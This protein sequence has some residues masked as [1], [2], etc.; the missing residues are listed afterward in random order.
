[1]WRRAVMVFQDSAR[2]GPDA[3]YNVIA[4]RNIEMLE[5]LVLGSSKRQRG[6]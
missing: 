5:Q 6:T 3:G 4:I 1:M 2:R